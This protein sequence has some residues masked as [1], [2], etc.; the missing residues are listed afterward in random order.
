MSAI[1]KICGGVTQRGNNSFYCDKCRKVWQSKGAKVYQL[2]ADKHNVAW[3][4][5]NTLI[6][7]VINGERVEVFYVRKEVIE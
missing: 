6:S 5:N 7:A 3:V 2:G 4:R 1:C